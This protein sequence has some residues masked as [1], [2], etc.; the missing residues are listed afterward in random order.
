MEKNGSIGFYMHDE[1]MI[2][3][4]LYTGNILSPDSQQI[5]SDKSMSLNK[6]IDSDPDVK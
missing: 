3:Y 5:Y 2:F 1:D 4:S 6:D